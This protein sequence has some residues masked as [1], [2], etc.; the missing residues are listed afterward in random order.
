MYAQEEA[1]LQGKKLTRNKDQEQRGA[2]NTDRN[3][4]PTRK[5]RRAVTTAV[6]TLA[7]LDTATL[8]YVSAASSL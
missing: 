6:Q 8:G 5:K 2:N 3:I 7:D 1:N 4:S